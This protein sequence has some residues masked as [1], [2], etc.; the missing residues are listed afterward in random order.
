MKKLFK[1]LLL[2][3]VFG[4]INSYATTWDEPW[5]DKVIK[6][7]S[8]FVLAKVISTDPD[9]GI[10]IFVLKTVS[11]IIL[12][13]TILINNFYALDICSRSGGH[14]AEFHTIPIDSCYFFINQNTKGEFCI[15]TPTTGFDYVKS[16]RVSATFR[17][18]YHQASVP[19]EVYDKAMTAVFN[20]Y[21]N[22]PYDKV[23][24]EKFVV[25]NLSKAPAGFD[26]NEINT[27]F[28]Q[29][30]A[31]ECIYH[32]KL[33][34]KET[35]V[36]SFLNDEKNFHNQ[37]SGARAM[38]AFN[39]E[40]SKQQLLK[41]ISDTTKRDFVRVMC[42]WSLSSFKPTKLKTQ[43]Q[44]V[45]KFASNESDGFAGNIMDPRVCTHIPSL[46]DALKELLDKL[47]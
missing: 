44:K 6:R 4:T 31:L 10:K 47:T 22:L 19:V 42:V 39:T 36:L 8:S 34:V 13:D 25:E 18:S 33:N 9:K 46:K 45:E 40:T 2:V 35:L 43:L 24:I 38:A 7:A 32:L 41:A 1:I 11:G 23:Y 5:A 15:A 30:V 26:E 16:G 27:F 28:L 12:S 17:H 14:G 29:H 21:H 20:N 37:V 3:T